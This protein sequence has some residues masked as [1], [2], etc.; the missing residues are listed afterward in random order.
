MISEQCVTRCKATN[1]PDCLVIM[2]LC[3][4]HQ[5][6]EPRVTSPLRQAP[7]YLNPHGTTK[8]EILKNLDFVLKKFNKTSI[9]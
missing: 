5:K 8:R 7:E 4:H 6:A 3:S 9:N 1:R 2:N